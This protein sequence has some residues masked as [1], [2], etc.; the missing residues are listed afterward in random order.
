M[1]AERTNHLRVITHAPS[2]REIDLVLEGNADNPR[3]RK[4][5]GYF[6]TAL[7][8]MLQAAQEAYDLGNGEDAGLLKSDAK[9]QDAVFAIRLKATAARST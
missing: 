5:H 8:G 1:Q 3:V 6:T 2:E 9:R 7:N 4:Q